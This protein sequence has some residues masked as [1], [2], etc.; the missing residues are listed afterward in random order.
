MP[1]AYT[2]HTNPYVDL[3]TDVMLR[4]HNAF[5]NINSEIQNSPAQAQT[6]H[7]AP[8][9]LNAAAGVM[10]SGMPSATDGLR[11]IFGYGYIDVMRRVIKGEKI[12][13]QFTY[14]AADEAEI[15]EAFQGVSSLIR[16]NITT[17]KDFLKYGFTSFEDIPTEFDR[18]LRRQREDIVFTYQD[19]EAGTEYVKPTKWAV[20]ISASNPTSVIVSGETEHIESGVF[21]RHGIL[22]WFNLELVAK[23]MKEALLEYQQ[24]GFIPNATC[25]TMIEGLRALMSNHKD[26]ARVVASHAKLNAGGDDYSELTYDYGELRRYNDSRDPEKFTLQLDYDFGFIDSNAVAFRFILPINQQPV[27]AVY[28][29]H[30]QKQ[31]GSHYGRDI[32]DL[33]FL[34]HPRICT[35]LYN[36]MVERFH[37]KPAQ[38]NFDI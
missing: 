36:E 32:A 28:G 33:W 38:L 20:Y 3:K 2:V 6:Y 27:G 15:K 37:V 13:H 29:Y 22:G 25:Y 19:I 16:E 26:D 9:F 35:Y 14:T 30:V 24:P 12:P 8:I 34:K 1:K 5:I 23:G 10:P 31:Y 17:K 21:H 11:E 7:I 18:T 4:M